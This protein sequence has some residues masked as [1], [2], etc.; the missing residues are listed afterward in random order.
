MQAHYHNNINGIFNDHMEGEEDDHI[1]TEE[2]KLDSAIG[3]LHN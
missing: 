1:S 3:A 2:E